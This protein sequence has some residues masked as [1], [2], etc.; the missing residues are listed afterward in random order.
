MQMALAIGLIENDDECHYR[1]SISYV[2]TWCSDNY[3]DLNM[4]KHKEMVID[5]RKCKNI[6]FPFAID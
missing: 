4:T 6:K 5:F 1:N 2:T 3:L